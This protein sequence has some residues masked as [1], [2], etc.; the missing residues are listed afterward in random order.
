MSD[1]TAYPILAPQ[2]TITYVV[3]RVQTSDGTT[4]AAGAIPMAK[5]QLTPAMVAAR[6]PKFTLDIGAGQVEFAAFVKGLGRWDDDS[7]RSMY[8]E[9]EL[10]ATAIPV[11]VSGTPASMLPGVITFATVRTPADL[12]KQ[13]HTTATGFCDA[14]GNPPIAWLNNSAGIDQMGKTNAVIAS[15]DANYLSHCGVVGYL[16]TETESEALANGQGANALRH[17][18]RFDTFMVTKHY[19][20]AAVGFRSYN[21]AKGAPYNSAATDGGEAWRAG[22]PHPP[23]YYTLR[24]KLGESSP[25]GGQNSGFAYYDRAQA[26]MMQ[27]FRTGELN[28]YFQGLSMGWAYRWKLQWEYGDLFGLGNE[29]GIATQSSLFNT[30][31]EQI[32]LQY[33]LNGDPEALTAAEGLANKYSSDTTIGNVTAYNSEARPMARE[34]M[35]RLW[36]WLV[37][38]PS[39]VAYP[40]GNTAGVNGVESQSWSTLLDDTVTRVCSGTAFNNVP[41]GGSSGVPAPG[42]QNYWQSSVPELSM[43]ADHQGVSVDAIGVNNFMQPMV[44]YALIKIFELY[45]T[46]GTQRTLIYNT[47]LANCNYLYPG[48]WEGYP[49]GS[50]FKPAADPLQYPCFRNEFLY[51]GPVKTIPEASSVDVLDILAL[52]PTP[53]AWLGKRNGGVYRSIAERILNYCVGSDNVSWDGVT[54]PSTGFQKTSAENYHTSLYAWGFVQ[55]SAAALAIPSDV[56]ASIRLTG[57]TSF[58]GSPGS[59]RSVTGLAQTAQR[60]GLSGKAYTARSNAPAVATVSIVGGTGVA[61]ITMV[62]SGTTQVYITADGIDSPPITVGVT[63]PQYR[64]DFASL[65]VDPLLSVVIA[66]PNGWT[67]SAATG[68]LVIGGSD[69]SFSFLNTVLVKTPYI[70]L[71]VAGV[72]GAVIK[73]TSRTNDPRG[74]IQLIDAAGKGFGASIV[75]A[76]QQ[77][78]TSVDDFNTTIVNNIAWPGATSWM[79][80]AKSGANFTFED[81]PDGIIWTLRSTQAL[82]AGMNTNACRL[83]IG[84]GQ[85]SVGSG[86]SL[87]VDNIDIAGQ[88]TT[89]VTSAGLR[90]RRNKHRRS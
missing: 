7:Y 24:Q 14:S 26:H 49:F 19:S 74:A 27:Y 51:N 60:F 43:A 21:I 68:A 5:G 57:G 13:F 17:K 59:V 45:S 37:T 20:D 44:D 65:V 48:E 31:P 53:F 40:E 58:V 83:V 55:Q 79:R 89:G 32:G 87:T 28:Y 84:V 67:A 72:S 90:W 73:I 29:P 22:F 12:A 1:L 50:P 2:A 33:F 88:V 54:T 23:A 39:N 81:S 4:R 10:G 30:Q 46:N 85:G 75:V 77:I 64:Q 86:I 82:P 61:T 3:T 42:W 78:G 8:V 80:F 25:G 52:Y 18:Q 69:P 38:R 36:A 63:T 56:T 76:Q 71:D 16:A 70:S 34:I 41:G 15:T 62:G 47:V 35:H 6:K 66:G 9:L 11:Y